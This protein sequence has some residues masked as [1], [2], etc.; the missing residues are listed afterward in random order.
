MI[1]RKRI[2]DLRSE[3][4][5]ARQDGVEVRRQGRER[6]PLL[7]RLEAQLSENDFAKRLVQAMEQ[8]RRRPT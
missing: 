7:R 1:R 3:L 8:S 4:R 2:K 6:E 5:K